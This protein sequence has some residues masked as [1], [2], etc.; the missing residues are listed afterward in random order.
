[1]KTVKIDKDLLLD[2]LSY[3][4]ADITFVKNNGEKR[5]MYCTR[6]NDLIPE[7]AR[8][9]TPREDGQP[10]RVVKVPDHIVRVYDMDNDDWRSFNIGR[11]TE[12]TI[13]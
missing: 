8:P 5:V 11:V 13:H 3:T 12:L 9:G 10:K 7:D 1:M 4:T 6:C 2:A